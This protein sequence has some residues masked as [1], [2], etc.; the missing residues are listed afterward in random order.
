MSQTL[1]QFVE[2]ILNESS[3]QVPNA[4]KKSLASFLKKKGSHNDVVVYD[5]SVL[6]KI[7]DLQ[8]SDIQKSK[9]I[10]ISEY[11]KKI[12][13]YVV[14]SGMRFGPPQQ[15]AGQ[16]WG[17]LEVYF[18]VSRPG[19]KMG[20][21]A[22]DIA[23]YYATKFAGGLMSDRYSV[24]DSAKSIWKKFKD[25]REDVEKKKFDNKDDPKT[26]PKIDDSKHQEDDVLN[27]D[28]QL[29]EKPHGLDQLEANHQKVLEYFKSLGGD[30]SVLENLIIDNFSNLFDERYMDHLEGN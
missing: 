14:L 17:A 15:D 4:S 16:S 12:S 5:P 11:E 9:R 28:Y 30:T 26:E 18:S 27:Y 29:Q 7:I 10:W 6:K 22:Y 1:K 21:V 19:S 24:T 13:E 23:M 3:S 25:S 8:K 20:P 2:M